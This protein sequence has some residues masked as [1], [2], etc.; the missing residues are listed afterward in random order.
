MSLLFGLCLLKDQLTHVFI[1]RDDPLCCF[2]KEAFQSAPLKRGFFVYL[3]ETN[4]HSDARRKDSGVSC[5]AQTGFAALGAAPQWVPLRWIRTNFPTN[6]TTWLTS[7][8][9]LNK[10]EDQKKAEQWKYFLPQDTLRVPYHEQALYRSLG[11]VK[12]RFLLVIRG[13]LDYPL[14]VITP[15]S[16]SWPWGYIL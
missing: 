12:F 1:H 11:R 15:L 6:L 7:M 3:C 9:C 10:R 4:W 16:Y 5:W 14:L 13:A 8:T 2:R